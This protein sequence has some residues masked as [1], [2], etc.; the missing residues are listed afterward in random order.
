MGGASA[1]GTLPDHLHIH[2]L[3]RFLGDTNFLA[4]LAQTKTISFDLLDLACQLRKA[5]ASC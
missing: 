5:F 4:C 1:G 2:V 3:P